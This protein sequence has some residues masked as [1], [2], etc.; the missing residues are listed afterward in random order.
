MNFDNKLKRKALIDTGSC[1]NAIPEKLLGEM[2]IRKVKLSFVEPRY[3]SVKMASGSPVAVDKA[4]RLTLYIA[5]YQFTDDFLVLP[6]MNSVIL[7]NPFFKKNSIWICPSNNLLK[8]PD[9]TVQ[10]N[11]IRPKNEKPKFLKKLKKIPIFLNKKYAIPPY[12]HAVLECTLKEN[13]DS[14]SGCSGVVIPNDEFENSTEIALTSSLSSIDEHGKIMISAVNITEHYVHVKANTMVA[15]FE[16]LSQ[17]QADQLIQI[18][19]QLIALA[20]VQDPN[21]LENGINQLVQ[22]NCSEKMSSRPP[23]EYGKLWFPTPETCFNPESLPP[24]QREIFDQIKH[25]QTLESINPKSSHDDREK[26]LENFKW[27]QSILTR[28]QKSEVENLLVEFSDIFAKHRFDV[29]YNTELKIKLTPEHNLPV[30]V[31][32]PLTPIHLRDELVVELALMHYYNLITTLS[33]SKYSSPVFAQRKS[34]GRLRILIDLRRINHLLRNDYINSNFP[35]SNMSDATNHFAGK[36]FLNKLDCSQAYHC[37]QM[38]DDL[39]V[40][41]LSFNFASRTY[42]YKCLA[43]GL[44]K[45]VT[46]FSSFVRHYLDQCL[47]ANI[48]TQYMDDIGSGVEK[49]E[50]LVPNL[51]KIFEC[52]RKS[53]LKLSP[54]KCQFGVQQITFLGKVITPAGIQPERE[55]IK[56]FL[57]KLTMPKT[58]KQV[59]RLVGFLQFWRDFIPNLGE[60]LLPFY[61]LLRK[62]VEHQI[63]EEQ[64]K[65]LEILKQDLQKATDL[66]LRLAKPGLQYVLLC[67]ASYYGAGFVLMIED[68]IKDQKNRQ[69]KTYAP[70]AFGTKLFNEAQLKF[71]IYYKEFLGLYFALEHFSHFIWGT[72]KP[73]IVLTDNKSLTSFFQSKSIPPSLWNFLDRLLSYNLVIAHI[74]GRANYAADFLSRVQ[75]DPDQTIQLKLSDRIPVQEIEVETIA[76]SPDVMLCSMANF[77]NL[78]DNNREQTDQNII[79]CLKQTGLDDGLLSQVESHVNKINDQAEI[80]TTVRIISKPTQVNAVLMND[81]KDSLKNISDKLEPLNLEAEQQKDQVIK[82]VIEWI[83]KNKVDDLKYASFELKKYGKQFNRLK[84]QS[85][86]LYREFY[87]HSGKVACLQYCLPKQL[88]KEVL[89]RLHNSRTAGHIGI[90]RTIREFRERFYFPGF[91]E[92]FIQMIKNCLTCIQQKAISNKSLRTFLQPVSS[93]Q[94]FPGDMMQIDIAGPFRGSSPYKFVLTGIDVFS[95]YLFATPLISA[96]AQKIAQELTSI[97]FKHSYIPKTIVSDLGTNLVAELMHE[98]SKLLEVRIR[99]ATL[100]HAQ[101]VGVVERSHGALKR[102]LKL[103]TNEQWSNWQL[104]VPLATYIHNTSYYSSIG[105]SPTSIFHGREPIKPLD[106]RFNKSIKTLDLKS[107][108]VTEIQDA[109]QKLF[110]ETKINL[111]HR[112]HQYR[113]YFDEKAAAQP[114]NLFSFCLIL[115]PKLMNQNDFGN[116]SMNVWIP[117]YRVEKVLTHSNYLIRKVGTNYTQC[118]HRIRLRPYEPL[119]SP[120]DLQQ[121]DP[122]L[123]VPE[124]ALGKY[125][126]EPELFDEQIPNLLDQTFAVDAP[127]QEEQEDDQPVSTTR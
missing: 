99:H 22:M 58:V 77:S 3:K 78:F 45:S 101:S 23:P 40:Q 10:L 70:V 90:L 59:K 82:K 24:L 19:P 51:R 4:V 73:V 28:E 34:S 2:Q 96:N 20:K 18:D 117:L 72:E 47:A 65:A 94:S 17:S 85:N 80:P 50:E 60:K 11:E 121:I 31:K 54:N 105:C 83:K 49:F 44:S 98:L 76:K 108:F 106:V 124:P 104:Y 103:N 56:K 7:G 122:K 118:L 39:S 109:M 64:E 102:I 1:A 112:Y 36:K 66:T 33:H 126:Q 63:T 9:M 27:E 93:L 46:G 8:L 30:Y 53:G 100:K 87:D 97:F 84:I 42:A 81:P 26:F 69:K 79:S 57:S 123:F 107:D 13:S 115:N 91:T 116:K 111:I 41:L 114:L 48:C 5:N 35:I 37:V 14:F 68:Y 43:Q 92:Y 127:E 62:N 71:S 55:R 12:S 15:S 52:I 75:T 29:G 38:A 119:E 25:F 120:V 125:R 95:K 113:R 89:Y 32:S 86:I 88:W 74:P 21:N 110:S 61:K 16:I 67:D 6:T